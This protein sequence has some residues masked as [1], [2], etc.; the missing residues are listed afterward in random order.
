[1]YV[2]LFRNSFPASNYFLL[3]DFLHC[4]D[5][6]MFC[7]PP[8]AFLHKL[9]CWFHANFQH[10]YHPSP[11]W[12][13]NQFLLFVLHVTSHTFPWYLL[14]RGSEQSVPVHPLHTSH[15]FQDT[16]SIFF[17]PRL[18]IY[19]VFPHTE[20]ICYLLSSLLPF[21]KHFQLILSFLLGRTRTVRPRWTTDC[22]CD[23]QMFTVLV[24]IPFLII[25]IKNQFGF[26][27]HHSW[28]LW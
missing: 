11:C 14:L 24:P 22:Y 19:Q 26:L 8:W 17:F 28:P 6:Y 3:M 1:M 7:N 23:K 25:P 13:G 18:T 27:D 21:S 5:F 16:F 4:C 12:R 20:I 10:P 15:G 9:A 2:T